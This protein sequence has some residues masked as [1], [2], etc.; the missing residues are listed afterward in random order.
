LTPKFVKMEHYVA[1]PTSIEEVYV[2][3]V[4]KEE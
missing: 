4:R 1:I 3:L 2:A